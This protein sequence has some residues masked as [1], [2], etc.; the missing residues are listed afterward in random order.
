MAAAYA[1]FAA[2][3][4]HCEN[5]P[6]TSILNSDGKV[7]KNY[8]QECKQVM[9]ESTADTVNDILRGV[10]DARRLR[11]GARPRQARRRQD[12]HDQQQHGGVVQ[13]LHARPLHRRDDRRRQLQ[14]AADHPERPERRRAHDRRGVRLHRGRARCGPRRCA[15][16]QDHLPDEDFTAAV[17]SGHERDRG[18]ASPTSSGCRCA[19]PHSSLAGAG[20]YVSIGEGRES[21][22]PEGTCREQ[23]ARRRRDRAAA[24]RRSTSIPRQSGLSPPSPCRR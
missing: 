18:G 8:P 15:P 17:T 7:F 3:G 21:D 13:R 9:Q 4:K 1:T 16:I 23:R 5:R 20:F 14:R 6:V 19:R 24:G 10:L 11:P 2:R 12:R 22:E